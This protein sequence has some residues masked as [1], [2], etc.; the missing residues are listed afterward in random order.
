MF[1]RGTSW[2]T[3]FPDRDSRLAV[4]E[5]LR[6]R[7]T[8][9]VHHDS[10]RP[11][12]MGCWSTDEV[13]TAQAGTTRVAVIGQSAVTAARLAE[14]AA[15]VDDISDLDRLA[16]TL[17]GSFHLIAAV[18]NR[19]RVQGSASGFRRVFATTVGGTVVTADRADVLARLGSGEFDHRWLAARLVDPGI[20]HPACDA[21]PWRD[22][23]AVPAGHYLLVEATGRS[24]VVRWWS[25]PEPSLSLPEGAAVLR[26]T[27]AT[28][29]S[30]RLDAVPVQ[31]PIGCDLSGGFDS[32]SLCFLAKPRW[33]DL[34]AVTSTGVDEGDDD[35][36][37]AQAAAR[38]LPGVQ[39]LVVAPD[40][41]P[42][43]FADIL[44]PSG[45]DEPYPGLRGQAQALALA[46]RLVTGGCTIQLT[47]HGGDE[48]VWTRR[49]YLYDL[50]RTRPW[51]FY[52]HFRGHQILRRWPARSAA[53]VLCD[54]RDYAA[55]L[56]DEAARLLAPAPPD[57]PA[58]W[59]PPLRLPFWATPA[60]AEAA[61]ALLAVAA[62]G[63]EPLSS[64]RGQHEALALVQTAGRFSRLDAQVVAETGL[65]RACPFLD[66]RVVEA[67][68]A[69]RAHE[70]TSPWRYKPLLAEAMRGIVPEMLLQ[71]R[72]KA[73]TGAEVAAGFRHHG[74]E[75]LALCDDSLLV[76]YGLVDAHRLRTAVSQA[77]AGAT[78]RPVLV[79]T[80]ACETWLRSISSETDIGKG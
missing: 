40:H 10:G 60:A 58:G 4:A 72:T 21:T 67:C 74:A 70:R 31:A 68:L 78:L 47:G 18:G 51:L 43:Q 23:R 56:G 38:D 20:P 49:A 28:A 80:L 3:V 13:V 71:R 48:V 11:W 24:R 53:R 65:T 61:E 34:I 35:A 17:P 44:R 32:T 76:R 14:T 16:T 15:R 25:P 39:R 63:A 46:D 66:D 29:V 57:G 42:R 55:W 2:F 6:S 73:D 41:R 12:L 62:D 5:L 19:I 37:W 75:L 27:L 52:R 8:H 36:M 30:I 59:G 7:A 64:S 69:V 79:Q 22:V 45:S 1:S 77:C 9:V 50:A 26:E 33:N 54:R